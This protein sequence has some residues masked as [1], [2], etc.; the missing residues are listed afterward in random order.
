MQDP[1]SP[2]RIADRMAIQDLMYRWCRS[3]DRL[4]FELMRSV[5]HPDAIDNHGAFTGGVEELV[6]WIRERHRT[7]TFSAHR[8]GNM[9]IEF[10]GPDLALV[11]T[12]AETVQRYPADGKAGLAQL[13]G[14]QQGTPGA[15]AVLNSYTRYI[16]RFERAMVNGE[17][18]AVRWCKTGSGS[19]TFRLRT[20]NRHQGG[21]QGGAIERIRCTWRAP[22]SGCSAKAESLVADC[23]K[24]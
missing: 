1:F 2:Q 4:D 12:Y 11:E 21:P 15:A 9:L 17:L 10:A 3:V 22:I 16:D 7:I 6:A 20:G 5:F 13:S 19:A 18:P 23:D 8:L 14:G 24:R